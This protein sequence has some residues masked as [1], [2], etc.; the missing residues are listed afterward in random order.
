[1]S[2]L[3]LLKTIA[4]TLVTVFCCLATASDKNDKKTKHLAPEATVAEASLSFWDV[5]NLEKPFI[6]T[7]P[8][9]SKGSIPV[10]KLGTDGGNKDMIVNL[11]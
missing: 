11:A 8:T 5:Q 10:G 9:H 6:D 4:A 1:M 2:K 7:A 3:K